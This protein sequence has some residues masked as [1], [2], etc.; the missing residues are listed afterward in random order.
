[1]LKERDNELDETQDK[2][3]GFGGWWSRSLSLR[4]DNEDITIYKG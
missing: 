3:E 4:V 2:L 1:M